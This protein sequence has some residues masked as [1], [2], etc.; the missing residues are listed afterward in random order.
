MKPIIGQ[1]QALVIAIQ[2]LE[3]NGGG[4]IW[5]H[6]AASEVEQG[7]HL[8]ADDCPCGPALLIVEPMETFPQGTIFH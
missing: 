5:V 1:A 8:E 6:S 7:D 2:Y 4:E 3:E